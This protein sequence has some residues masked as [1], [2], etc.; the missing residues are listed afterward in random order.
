[1]GNY[2][3]TVDGLGDTNTQG[4]HPDRSMLMNP[5]LS[6]PSQSSLPVSPGHD[7]MA[8]P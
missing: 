6:L 4:L 8:E 5:R 2:N 1:M 3:E 7:A